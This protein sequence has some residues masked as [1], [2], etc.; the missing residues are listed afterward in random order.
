[1]VMFEVREPPQAR[2]SMI[3]HTEM[4]QVMVVSGLKDQ[5]EEG[6]LE[7]KSVGLQDL[8]ARK[9]LANMRLKKIFCKPWEVILLCPWVR[10]SHCLKL[11]DGGCCLYP[12]SKKRSYP[13][14]FGQSEDFFKK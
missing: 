7:A 4:S 13:H 3:L 1:M 5:H 2:Q 9:W 8:R 11:T 14:S 10:S 6:L 12:W